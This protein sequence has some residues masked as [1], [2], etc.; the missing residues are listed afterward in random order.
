MTTPM[1]AVPLPN[2]LPRLQA[3]VARRSETDYVFDFWT[4]LGWTL[5]TCGVFGVYVFYRLFWRSVEHNKRRLEVL[6]A[7]LTLAWER[8]VAAGRGE[9]LTPRFQAAGAHLNELRALTGEFRDPVIWTIISLVSSGIGHIVGYVFLDMDLVRHEAAEQAVEQELAVIYA[10][11]GAP[12]AFPAPIVTKQRHS[13][14]GRVIALL[15]SCGLYGLWWLYD[16]MTEGNDH[17]RRNWESDDALWSAAG[18]L[19]AA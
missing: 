9:E 14:V 2:P 11:L 5:L 1:P 13:Y 17:Q 3:G 15:A 12:V 18:R 8:A 10:A 7:G 6:D 16:L 19:A 4:A